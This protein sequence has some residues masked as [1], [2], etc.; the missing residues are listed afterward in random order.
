MAIHAKRGSISDEIIGDE[1]LKDVDAVFE[2]LLNSTFQEIQARGRSAEGSDRSKK[3]RS[4]SV[5]PT[6]RVSFS[7]SVAESNVGNS[8]RSAA[9]I[10][11]A[12]VAPAQTA[13]AAQTAQAEAEGRDL[14]SSSTTTAG[15]KRG[16]VNRKQSKHKLVA[17]EVKSA[18]IV[19]NSDP[20]NSNQI[21]TGN[22]NNMPNKEVLADPLG[23]LPTSHTKKYLP[24][25]QTWAGN[26]TSVSAGSSNISPNFSSNPNLLPHPIPTQ[27]PSPTQSEYDTCPDPWEDY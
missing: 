12:A 5:H 11:G 17:G 26:P 20:S 23:A 8:S 7:S 4:V 1:D 13:L 22:G 14:K 16:T 19:N 3:K 18:V 9:A 24:R 25:Q 2:S 15:P 10:S 6:S 27:T 21:Q